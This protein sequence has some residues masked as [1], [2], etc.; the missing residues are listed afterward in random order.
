MSKMVT[1]LA[2][3]AIAVMLIVGWHYVLIAERPFAADQP[4][5]SPGEQVQFLQRAVG[6]LQAQ[7]N[8]AEDDAAQATAQAQQWHEQLEQ[9]QAQVKT[10]GEQ[11]TKASPA[12]PIV[13]PAGVE[14]VK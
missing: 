12:K 14:Q 11:L 9:A 1:K 4:L 2:A 10:L 3:I 6:V 13:T 7:R 8:K 5:P